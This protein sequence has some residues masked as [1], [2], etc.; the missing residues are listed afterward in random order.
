MKTEQ[1]I[2]EELKELE[3]RIEEFGKD[4]ES[5]YALDLLMEQ[6]YA[7]RRVIDEME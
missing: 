5:Y 6:T 2:R 4:V 1:E 3:E 7:L